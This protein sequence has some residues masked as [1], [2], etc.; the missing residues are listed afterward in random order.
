MKL[1]YN[2]KK[3]MILASRSFY[4]YVELFMAVV[5]LVILLFVIPENFSAKSTEYIYWDVPE[6]ARSIFETEM[7]DI[8]LDG[9]VE[10][11]EL[12]VGDTTYPATLYESD[13]KKMYVVESAE[14]AKTLAD[15]KKNLGAVI[16]I[17]D[18]GEL[19]YKYYLQGYES[20]RLK[21]LYLVF[22]NR[23]FDTVQ[24]AFDAQDVRPLSTGY[25]T[26]T[27]RENVVPSILVFNGS[28]MGLFILAAYI[29]L[30]KQEGVIKAIAVSASSVWHYLA[31][32]LGVVL[33][34]SI[35]SSVVIVL[36]V[37]GFK[38]NYLMMLLFLITTGIFASALGLLLSSFYENIMQAFGALYIVVIAL[39]LPNI[40]YFIPSW[41][42]VWMR[43]IPTYPMLEGF[44]EI[45]LNGDMG[46]V[47]TASAAF[48]AA[49][50]ILFFWADV[51]F[52]KTLTV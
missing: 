21:N 35:I 48:L 30:D 42:P 9:V 2:F 31:S 26:L 36:P 8:D 51:R 44:K 27:D 13:D 37:M 49:G 16:S 5:F 10:T 20:Q 29:F 34:T 40:A 52:R 33:V 41:E 23:D 4:F 25:D 47:L 1:W 15:T 43:Y 22:H 17:D 14:A 46:Y 32:K 7:M 18:A 11:A 3:E 38:I 50:A 24:A 28:L 6:A 19:H 39:M 45:M 12:K